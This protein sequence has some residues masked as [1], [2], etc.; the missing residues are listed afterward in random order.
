MLSWSTACQDWEDRIVGGRSL[1]PCAPLFPAEAE[2]GL[3]VFK[4]LRV[5]DVPG[6]PPLGAI[7]R[8]WIFDFVA[9]VFGAYDPDAER[10]L[11]KDFFLTVSKKNAKSTI[12]AG[13][14]MTA[15]ILNPRHSAE[16]LIIAP[17]KEIAD[18]SF[19]PAADMA[20]LVNEEQTTGGKAP[21]FRVYRR[22]RR[23]VH[24]VTQSEL[25][26]VAAEDDTVT[27]VKATVVL[28]DELWL[29]GKKAGAMS[30]LREARGGLASRPEGFVVY[31]STMS[32]EVPA[33]EFKAKL[34]YGRKVRDGVITDPKFL[35]VIYEFPKRFLDD[36]SYKAPANFYITNPNLGAS[37][38]TEYL[39]EEFRTAENTSDAS[40]IDFC[41]KHLNVEI[42]QSLGSDAWAGASYWQRQADPDLTLARIIAECDVLTGGVDGGGLDDLLS[43]SFVGRHAVTRRWMHW[44]HAWAHEMVLERRKGE[45]SRLRDFER[46]GNL[47]VVKDMP[48]AFADLAARVADVHATGKLAHLGMDPFGVGM[49][50]DALAELDVPTDLPFLSAV[51][52]GYQLQGAIKTVEVKL[53]AGELVH[54]GQPIMAWAVGNAKVEPKGNAITITKQAAGSAKIDP[55]MSL[56]DA[57]ALMSKNPAPAYAE[58]QLFFV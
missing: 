48:I 27:G 29:F 52:Q 25:K 23:I 30:M 46:D 45:A 53:A 6:K 10:Q 50:I 41:A 37:V 7:G 3:S 54:A 13:I 17:T 36:G 55:L 57:A 31:L 20:D 32:N 34:Q 11:I 33:G 42:G 9:V 16:F 22:D 24:L 4:R 58:P 51:S 8:D 44:Q 40:L 2:R 49:I 35:P 21:L 56:L 5:S 26:V 12:A 1:V 28:V 15:L 19:D 38:D 18:N 47:T 39:V 43:L 14:M